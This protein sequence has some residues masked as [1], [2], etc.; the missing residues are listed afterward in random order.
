[1]Q[2]ASGCPFAQHPSSPRRSYATLIDGTCDYAESTLPKFGKLQLPYWQA[3]R[4]LHWSVPKEIK[5]I[6]ISIDSMLL[7]GRPISKHKLKWQILLQKLICALDPNSNKCR[8]QTPQEISIS[9]QSRMESGLSVRI[10]S[11][12]IRLWLTNKSKRKPLNASNDPRNRQRFS[13]V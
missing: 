4:D 3:E 2:S 6:A 10:V 8:L 5:L 9:F 11:Q 13:N 1:M 12:L 7:L